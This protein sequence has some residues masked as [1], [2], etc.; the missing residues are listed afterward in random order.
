MLL[1]SRFLP[2][3]YLRLPEPEL[4][5]GLPPR[6]KNL[7]ISYHDTMSGQDT[8][9][10][11]LVLLGFHSPANPTPSLT[12]AETTTKRSHSAVSAKENGTGRPY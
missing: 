11:P 2:L 12:T 5:S 9:V 3:L 10:Y 8:N 7:V 1:P 4:S 6:L